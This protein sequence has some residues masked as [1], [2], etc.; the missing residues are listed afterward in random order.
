MSAQLKIAK[1][2]RLLYWQLL[3][4]IFLLM[5][6][7]PAQSLLPPNRSESLIPPKLS[8]EG[9]VE[10]ALENNPQTRIA[11]QGIKLA[12]LKIDEANLA[13]K[14]FVQFTSSVTGG[15]NP[16]FVFGSRLEQGRFAP[17]NFALDSLNQPDPLINFRSQVSVQKMLFDQ[18][19]SA[20]RV[21]RARL[22][23]SQAELQLEIV[24]QELRFQI[25]RTYYGTV[26]AQEMLKVSK[27]AVK[28]AKANS[29]K[30]KDMVEVG[31]TTEADYLAAEVELA[32][33]SQHKLEA[34]SGVFTTNAALN[35]ILGR[36]P[37]FESEYT[38][39]LTEKYFP[40]EDRNE[41]IAI[42]LENRPEMQ[43]AELAIES[44]REQKKA[45]VN[46]QK[47]PQVNAFGNF[48]YSSPYLAAGSTDFTVGVSLTYT[49]FDAG[50]KNRLEQATESESLVA[51][52]KENLANQIRL[53]VIRAEQN[54]QT[55][56]AKI[57][58]SIKTIAQAE[59]VLRITKDRYTTGLVIFNEVI[60]AENALVGAKSGLLAARFEYTISYASV[61]LATGR[62]NDVRV[63][64]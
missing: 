14:P 32:N 41:L 50:R 9:A 64:R 37:E 17:S 7:T 29:K 52:E 33:A 3:L 26:L 20:S 11:E 39:D 6:S 28:S 21:T 49:L 53:E 22:G 4:L 57:Q 59:E 12:E 18:K 24:R 40:L 51:L 63:F 45:L 1:N 60:R 25:I 31:M 13:K 62:L 19:Q 2:L 38:D 34:E 23:R 44:S 16:V 55:S 47:L 36:P 54:Y 46:Q 58:V 43:K 10:K 35:I 48:G 30:A 15:N 56:R 5:V 27:E 61:L 8:L 42:A